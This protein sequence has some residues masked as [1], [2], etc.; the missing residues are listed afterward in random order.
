MPVADPPRRALAG[1]ERQARVRRAFAQTVASRQVVLVIM[2]AGFATLSRLLEPEA[3]GLFAIATAVMGLATALSGFGLQWSLIREAEADPEVARSAFGLALATST[4]AALALVAAAWAAPEALMPPGLRAPLALLG[5]ALMV[6]P[7][8]MTAEAALQRE[9]RFGLLSALAP[10]RTA[11]DVGVA[12]GLALL[13]WGAAALAAGLLAEAVF[14]ALVLALCMRDRSA[15]VPRFSGWRRFVA[16]G[17]DFTLVKIVSAAGGAGATAVVAA[18]LD[19][20]SLGLLNRARRLIRLFDASVLEGLKPVVLPA[21]S[22]ALEDGVPPARL[23]LLKLEHLCGLCWP[24]YL[25]V[26]LLAEPLI[27]VALGPGWA[28]AVPVVWA[29]AAMAFA[30]P[31]TKM[32]LKLFAA[33]DLTRRMI[34]IGAL[35]Q[36]ASV[37]FVAAGAAISLE[38]AAF[39]LA[40]AFWVKAAAV[41]VVLKR[42]IG[43]EP[44]AVAAVAARGAALAA[45]AAA[46]PVA[47]LS[48]APDWPALAVLALGGALAALGWLV[49]AVLLRHPLLPELREALA[50]VLRVVRPAGAAS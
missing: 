40:A 30:F 46:G 42:T 18:L 41:S 14:A 47:A 24:A 29:L 39:G 35:H 45:A 15:L 25:V 28:D 50:S 3:F 44:R 1:T 38:A 37:A 20:A 31:F 12:V 26:A 10:A 23:Y 2:A 6:Q 49:G 9:I 43:Y 5:L 17:I 19:L 16:F 7:V 48:A 34:G 32:S 33:L 22:R 21:F 11:V 4:T 27:D 36:T 8:T 13:G